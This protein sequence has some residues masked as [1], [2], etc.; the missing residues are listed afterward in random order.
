MAIGIPLPPRNVPRDRFQWRDA[1]TVFMRQTMVLKAGI[2]RALSVTQ[3]LWKRLAG[4]KDVFRLRARARQRQRA[5]FNIFEEQYDGLIDVL[6]AAAHEGVTSKREGVYREVRV[7]MLKHYPAI[8]SRIRSHWQADGEVGVDP[9]RPLFIHA[10]L[11][12][13]VNAET[14][15]ED[16]M[17]SRTA[18]ESY[19]DE[20]DTQS[21]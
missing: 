10:S 21:A 7:W 3:V 8:A 6:C 5:Q 15:I 16:I 14:G 17:R 11:E 12:D 4:A 13:A 18:L 9:F 1:G 20:L 19:R 2:L